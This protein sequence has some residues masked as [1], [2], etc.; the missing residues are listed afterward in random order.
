MFVITVIYVHRINTES[1][2]NPKIPNELLS[3]D[4]HSLVNEDKLLEHMNSLNRTCEFCN[5]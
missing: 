2:P 1:N 3:A 5:I 4:N